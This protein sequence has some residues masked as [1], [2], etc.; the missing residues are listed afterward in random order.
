MFIIDFYPQ[1]L[2]IL[3]TTTWSISNEHP[4]ANSYMSYCCLF[5]F[6]YRLRHAGYAQA[7]AILL[8][9]TTHLMQTKCQLAC[10]LK[11]IFN[12]MKEHKRNKIVIIGVT[13]SKQNT[14]GAHFHMLF[15]M[16]IFSNTFHTF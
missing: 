13:L 12:Q 9:N 14:F 4:F 3:I 7:G 11:Q 1:P 10:D 8:N 5:T 15:A 6:L 16:S 2:Q